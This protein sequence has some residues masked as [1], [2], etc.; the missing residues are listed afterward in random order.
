MLPAPSSTGISTPLVQLLP[1]RR[2]QLFLN[3]WGGCHEG[4]NTVRDCYERNS[5]LFA[6][7]SC[8]LDTLRV[9]A[10]ERI[11]YWV[12]LQQVTAKL[13]GAAEPIASILRVTE[14]FRRDGDEWKLVH[15]H[16]DAPDRVLRSA[17]R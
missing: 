3:P 9:G 2:R 13:Q 6:S 11:G 12:F 16:A 7:G 17:G 1:K 15:R 8:T 10:D 14:V 5:S 4:A